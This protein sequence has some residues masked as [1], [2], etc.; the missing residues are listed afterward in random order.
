M[1]HSPAARA[2]Q[3]FAATQQLKLKPAE[4]SNGRIA[5]HASLFSPSL[6]GKGQYSITVPS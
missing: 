4:Q 6:S 1:Y 3:I 5:S 2:V